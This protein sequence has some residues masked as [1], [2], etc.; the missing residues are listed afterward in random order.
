MQRWRLSAGAWESPQVGL[1]HSTTIDRPCKARELVL[2]G[3]A[4]LCSTGAYVVR[5]E[6]PGALACVPCLAKST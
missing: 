3:T 5:Y 4:V 2:P 1:L 6:L